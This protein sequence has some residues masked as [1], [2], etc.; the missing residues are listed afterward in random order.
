V[1]N[2]AQ[3]VRIPAS[4]KT[5]VIQVDSI[6]SQD[7]D[8]EHKFNH[9]LLDFK[10]TGDIS[11]LLRETTRERIVTSQQAFKRSRVNIYRTNDDNKRRDSKVGRKNF[12]QQVSEIAGINLTTHSCEYPI[13][14][15]EFGTSTKAGYTPNKAQKPNQ[16][17]FLQRPNLLATESYDEMLSQAQV[18]LF[19][20]WDGHGSSGHN[21]SS[22]I[23]NKIPILIKR[24]L[25]TENLEIKDILTEVVTTVDE[26]LRNSKIGMVKN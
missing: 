18:H 12:L 13:V 5:N 3:K 7:L 8:E 15:E 23:K 17:S 2:R 26:N 1:R 24:S 14:I 11:K 16:D 9:H 19:G 20:V 21:V 6:E 10:K 4:Y 22:Y 25:K